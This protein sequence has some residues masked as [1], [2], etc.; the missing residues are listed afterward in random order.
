MSPAA[1]QE[2][3]ALLTRCPRYSATALRS[4]ADLAAALGVRQLW[5]KDEG[6]RLGLGSFKALGGSYAVIRLFL[7][8]AARQLRREVKPWELSHAEVR[9]VGRN[10]VFTCATDGNHGRSVAAAAR[11]VGA[12]AVVF[13]HAGVPEPRVSAIRQL[14]ADVRVVPG[15]YEDAVSRLIQVASEEGWQIVS[16]KSWPGYED[17]PRLIAQGYSVI[18]SEIEAV[19]DQPPTHVFVQAGVGGIAATVAVYSAIAYGLQKPKIIVVEPDRAACLYF[20]HEAGR[21]VL[22]PH[23]E[24][25]VMAMLEC[26]EPSLVAWNVLS[27]LADAFMTVSETEAVEAASRLRQPIGGD[28]CMAT[29]ESAATGLAGLLV[30]RRSAE[31][32]NALDIGAQSRVLLLNTEGLA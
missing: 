16:D 3:L 14:G 19:L 31:I 32:C 6:A 21:S 24:P 26:Y 23:G 2:A 11:L 27:R 18:L 8:E 7:D 28:P 25:T 30:A 17:V 29:S 12:R 1:A 9:E 15:S 5:V 20:S 22:I 13:V 4:L 10:M